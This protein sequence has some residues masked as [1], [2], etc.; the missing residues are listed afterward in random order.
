MLAFLTTDADVSALG[1]SADPSPRGGRNVQH[2]QRRRRHVDERHRNAARI[3]PGLEPDLDEFANA[4]LAACKDLTM[5]MARDAEGMTRI[6][7]LTVTGAH[8]NEEAKVAAK[9]I[10]GTI[11]SSAAG[12]EATPI[13]DGYWRP[14]DRPASS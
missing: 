4:V 11:S 14:R 7:H 10:V 3:G 6:A 2:A 5:Q 1:A 8:T 13:G 12:T 9:A